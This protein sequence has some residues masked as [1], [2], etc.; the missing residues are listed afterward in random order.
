MEE[1]VLAAL[2][3]GL[4][5]MCFLEHMEEG[6][7]SNRITWLSDKEFDIFFKEG[8]FLREKYK[9]AIIIKLG[10]EVGYNPNHKKELTA[11]IAKFPFD[12]IGL[13]YHFHRMNKAEP[14]YNLVSKTE[15]RLNRLSKKRAEQL[16]VDYY[17]ILGEATDYISA[18]MVC[19]LD[20]ALRYHPAIR[21]IQLPWDSLLALLQNIK[22]NG[23][24]IELNTSGIAIRNEVFPCKEIQRKALDYEIPFK[25][26]SDSHSPEQVGGFFDR[27]TVI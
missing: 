13:S 6:I 23:M 5:E 11:R 18:D 25:A 7:E 27:L 20:A 1:Y 16:L 19:H 8:L 24:A 9:N 4:Q 15:S 12:F 17:T 3:K 21:E 10:V 22:R 26:G 2:N 14:H